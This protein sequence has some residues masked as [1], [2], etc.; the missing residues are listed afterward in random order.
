MRWE[1][2]CFVVAAVSEFH[3]KVETVDAGMMLRLEHFCHCGQVLNL[4]VLTEE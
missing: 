4:V 3:G 1:G 2:N